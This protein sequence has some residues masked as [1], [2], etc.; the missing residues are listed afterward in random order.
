MSI[1]VFPQDRLVLLQCWSRIDVGKGLWVAST[2]SSDLSGVL[3]GNIASR[4]GL[5]SFM[6]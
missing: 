4:R 1:S 3:S 5:S 6:L 2:A